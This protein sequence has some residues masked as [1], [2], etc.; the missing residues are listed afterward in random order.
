MYNLKIVLFACAD[1]CRLHIVRFLI[2]I[3][4]LLFSRDKKLSNDYCN[5]YN[6]HK[7]FYWLPFCTPY[8]FVHL[9]Y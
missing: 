1:F 4:Q 2:Y 6:S 5:V 3:S 9:I 8:L 7:N